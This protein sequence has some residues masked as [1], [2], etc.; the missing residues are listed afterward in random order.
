MTMQATPVQFGRLAT[1]R[2]VAEIKKATGDAAVNPELCLVN[3]DTRPDEEIFQNAIR[4]QVYIGNYLNENGLPEEATPFYLITKQ[5]SRKHADT[6]E[7]GYKHF[8]ANIVQLLLNTLG[9]KGYAGYG[10]NITAS[11][12]EE[13]RRFDPSILS[14]LTAVLNATGEFVARLSPTRVLSKVELP[15]RRD[16]AAANGAYDDTYYEE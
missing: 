11:L 6:I 9:L 12:P 8:K 3:D 10:T 16:A 13:E 15:A 14:H 4:D 2:E 7:A 1:Q 5:P